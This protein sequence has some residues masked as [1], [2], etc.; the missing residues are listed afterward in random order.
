MLPDEIERVKSL[1]R[2]FIR[3]YDCNIPEAAHRIW[4]A[5]LKLHEVEPELLTGVNFHEVF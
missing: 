5:L 4:S 2:A 1:C 3:F